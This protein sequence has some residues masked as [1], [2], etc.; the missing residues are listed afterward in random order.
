MVDGFHFSDHYA[1]RREFLSHRNQHPLSVVL[2]LIQHLIT[3]QDNQIAFVLFLV[4][5]FIKLYTHQVEIFQTRSNTFQHFLSFS[6]RVG[7]RIQIG[8]ETGTYFLDSGFE[9]FA[10]KECHEYC[11]VDFVSLQ[12]NIKIFVNDFHFRSCRRVYLLFFLN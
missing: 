11:F 6:V 5:F 8:M 12:E 9:F 3:E 4:F 7:T 1:P 2:R 10:L